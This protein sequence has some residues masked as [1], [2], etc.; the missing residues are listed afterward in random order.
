MHGEKHPSFNFE[1]MWR[2]QDTSRRSGASSDSAS[3]TIT[4]LDLCEG[5]N[6][7]GAPARVQSDVEGQD[8]VQVQVQDPVLVLVRF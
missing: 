7:G 4:E 8:Q 5:L 6:P 2:K 3:Q 1:K